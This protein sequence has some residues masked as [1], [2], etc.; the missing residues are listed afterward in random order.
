MESIVEELFTYKDNFVP[1]SQAVEGAA[2]KSRG[3]RWQ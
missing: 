2:A 3:R 1:T